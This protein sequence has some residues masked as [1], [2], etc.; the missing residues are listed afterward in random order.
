MGKPTKPADSHE[1]LTLRLW[2][3]DEDVQGELLLLFGGMI[4]RAIAANFPRLKPI[5]VEDVVAEA[6]RRFWD[7]RKKY[8][9]KRDIRACLYRIALNVAR[10]LTGGR[11]KW[12]KARNRERIVSEE[13][14][15]HRRL[16][17]DE[18]LDECEAKQPVLCKQLRHVI[19]LLPEIQQ[20]VIWAYGLA[21]D[22]P[23]DA[24]ILGRELGEKYKGGV[25]IPA[26]TI[27]QYK[28][29]AKETIITEMRKCG[30]DLEKLGVRP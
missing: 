11:L 26:G 24:A 8:D 21:G 1:D 7:W 10:E 15:E 20:D 5:E 29:R 28:R 27:R 6:I 16:R 14:F 22:F 18:Q 25:P 13:W 2:E 23:L 17:V 3:N 4:E 12:Q 9:G 30:F 19:E